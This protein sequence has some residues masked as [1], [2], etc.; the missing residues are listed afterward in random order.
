MGFSGW[1]RSLAVVVPCCAPMKAAA[2]SERTVEEM[3][4]RFHS[5]PREFMLSRPSR[6]FAAAADPLPE[7]F[8]IDPEIL[9][10]KIESR[11]AIFGSAPAEEIAARAGN[12]E[13]LET[14]ID[15]REL[16]RTD[17]MILR[18]PASIDSRSLQSGRIDGEAWTGSTW[19]MYLGHTAQRYELSAARNASSWLRAWNYVT[20]AGRTFFEI[21]VG[22]SSL[23]R[24]KLSPAEKYDLL[25]GRAKEFREGNLSKREWERG[26][27]RQREL[28]TVPKWFGYCHGWAAASVMMKRP[29][30]VAEIAGLDGHQEVKFFPADIKALQAE[31]WANALPRVR[32]IGGRCDVADPEVDDIGRIVD[33]K[34]FNPNPAIFYL[35]LVNHVSGKGRAL[36]IDATY[37]EEVWNQPVIAYALRYFNPETGRASAAAS[38]STIPLAAYSRDKFRRYRSAA[39]AQVVG[40]AIEIEYRAS[41]SQRAAPTDAPANDRTGKATYLMDLELDARGKLVGGEWYQ[42]R[43]PDF[44]WSPVKDARA[45]SAFESSA[46]GTW[47]SGQP[48][49]ESW[50]RAAR[51]AAAHGQPLAKIVDRLLATSRGEP[52]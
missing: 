30:G 22:P 9:A 2:I 50:A 23:A 1:V 47:T 36:L 38:A 45:I 32:F 15:A 13:R 41:G 39:A 7:G 12:N 16:A 42:A 21:A 40:V 26:A 33:E 5:A 6:P 17:G 3:V 52:R 34:C 43:H 25:I 46:T 35:A 31:L 19:P 14:I 18:D 20:A 11:R 44:L 24:D 28:G 27:A 4:A 49:P 8:L 29:T 48:V 37:D 51:G 10:A